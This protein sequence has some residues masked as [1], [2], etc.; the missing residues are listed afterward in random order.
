MWD[1]IEVEGIMESPSS[2][3]P[4]STPT[5]SQYDP[6]S[7]LRHITNFTPHLK[8]LESHLE[9]HS[10]DANPTQAENISQKM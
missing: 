1:D 7:R 3:S 5:Q 2:I 8:T 4:F 6:V 9:V 10:G